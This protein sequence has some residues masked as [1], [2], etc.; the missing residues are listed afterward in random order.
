MRSSCARPR[1]STSI[2][3]APAATRA[4]PRASTRISTCPRPKGR[5]R[6]ESA[7]LSRS[8]TRLRYKVELQYDVL[9][10]TDFIFIVHAAQTPQQRVLTEAVTLTP[11]EPFVVETDPAAGNRL[12]RTQSAP[13]SFHVR[14]EGHVE[15]LHHMA[16]PET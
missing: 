16:N 3:R 4:R 13:G 11:D 9:A 14:Y 8:R 12:L 15:V 6:D 2:P 5:M 1:Y 10:P 7:T